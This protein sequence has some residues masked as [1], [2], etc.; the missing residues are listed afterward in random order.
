M[1][2]FLKMLFIMIWLVSNSL[3][4][5]SYT[6]S[7]FNWE[8]VGNCRF[9]SKSALLD[10]RNVAKIGHKIGSHSVGGGV[11]GSF[12]GVLIIL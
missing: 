9:D 5:C 8:T 11:L 2:F 3:D 7:D 10:S 12:G 6:K 4:D 1:V